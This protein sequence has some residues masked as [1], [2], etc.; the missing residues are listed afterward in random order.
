MT[1]RQ[2]ARGLTGALV[3]PWFI[4]FALHLYVEYRNQAP[5]DFAYHDS[6]FLALN[7]GWIGY[8]TLVVVLLAVYSIAVASFNWIGKRRKP[9]RR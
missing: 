3:V 8:F 9:G 1:L 4:Y 7:V 5:D 2:F 6:Y